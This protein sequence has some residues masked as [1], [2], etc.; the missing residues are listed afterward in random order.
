MLR[1]QPSLCCLQ[2]Q[3]GVCQVC[4][5]SHHCCCLTCLLPRLLLSKGA[6]VNMISGQGYSC[7]HTAVMGDQLE[8]VKT[9]L[10]A[11]AEV[12]ATDEELLTPLHFAARDGAGEIAL[13]LVRAGANLTAR[14]NEGKTPKDLADFVNEQEM[15][16]F[17]ASC[18]MGLIPENPPSKQVMLTQTHVTHR[19]LSSVHLSY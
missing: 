14:Q 7:L 18:E 15:T 3:Y 9:L 13:V 10:L 4:P 12:N 8:I 5:Y 16:A 1:Y 11:G 6:D 19:Y 17:L 2:G